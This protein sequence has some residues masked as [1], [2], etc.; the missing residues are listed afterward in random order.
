[1]RFVR[2]SRTRSITS[3]R[4]ACDF[5]DAPVD[6][7]RHGISDGAADGAAHTGA[8]RHNVQGTF[9]NAR[10]YRAEI[11]IHVPLFAT[12]IASV[13]YGSVSPARRSTFS[14]PSDR[15]YLSVTRAKCI[16]A[17]RDACNFD[18]VDSPKRVRQINFTLFFE[19][20]PRYRVRLERR[21]G[22]DRKYRRGFIILM[23]G[24]KSVLISVFKYG[25]ILREK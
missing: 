8:I 16:L 5:A 24:K 25:S 10:A 11:D 2:V 21:V 13:L 19:I 9:H 18:E 7:A 17:N 23:S 14:R 1:M 12:Y 15:D 4:A 20:T 22:N 6:S 3:W